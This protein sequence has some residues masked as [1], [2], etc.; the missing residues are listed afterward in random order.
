MN[1]DE[2]EVWGVVAWERSS[3]QSCRW[4]TITVLKG[5]AANDGDTTDSAVK[6]DATTPGFRAQHLLR[7]CIWQQGDTDEI[8]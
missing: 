6:P 4:E 3:R 5:R 8:L 2:M 7:G 1:Q